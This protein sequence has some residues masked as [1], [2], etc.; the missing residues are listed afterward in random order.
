AHTAQRY[1]ASLAEHGTTAPFASEMFDFD[2]L[3]AVIGTPEILEL[4]ARYEGS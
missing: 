1:Y 4:S 2:G 3:N